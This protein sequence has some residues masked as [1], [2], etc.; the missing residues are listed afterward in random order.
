MKPYILVFLI[1]LSTPCYSGEI[2]G[3][4]DRLFING[5]VVSVEISGTSYQSGSAFMNEPLSHAFRHNQEITLL[6]HVQGSDNFIDSVLFQSGEYHS[7]IL[8]LL[9]G[10]LSAGAFALGLGVKL[11]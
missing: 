5:S 11:S 2:T 4:I 10:A 6:Y 1:F 7:K 9:I 3:R 8:S